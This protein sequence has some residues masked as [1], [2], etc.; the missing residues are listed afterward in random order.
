VLSG[1]IEIEDGNLGKKLAVRL[2]YPF[3]IINDFLATNS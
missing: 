3:K 1:Q 2:M